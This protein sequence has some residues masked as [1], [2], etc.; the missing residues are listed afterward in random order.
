VCIIENSYKDSR[1]ALL[2]RGWF[3]NPDFESPF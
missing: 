3:E 2:K 1:K